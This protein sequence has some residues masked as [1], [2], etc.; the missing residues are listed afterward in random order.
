MTANNSVLRKG[1]WGAYYQDA[2][3]FTITTGRTREECG[4]SS[5]NL[6]L[7]TEMQRKLQIENLPALFHEFIHYIHELSTH[8][9]TISMLMEM[10]QRGVFSHWLEKDLS[11]SVSLGMKGKIEVFD[12]YVKAKACSDILE[13]TG[14]EVILGKLM[15]ML[16][17][18]KEK[19]V[20]DIPHELGYQQFEVQ[21]P[22]ITF[23]DRKNG[24]VYETKLRF[25]K[26]YIYEGIAYELDREIDRQV[27]GLGKIRDIN[28]NS[29][30]T[31][32]RNVAI[33]LY[34]KIEKR[35]FLSLAVI[36]LQQADCGIA[37]INLVTGLKEYCKTQG[38][39]ADFVASISR[40]VKTQLIENQE[41]LIDTV[42]ECIKPYLGRRELLEG[43]THIGKIFKQL[44]QERIGN[45][46][47]EVDAVMDG[48]FLAL[49]DKTDV[50]DYMYIFKDEKPYMR[51]FL[52]SAG[53]SKR[54]NQSMKV[55]IAYQHYFLSHQFLATAEVEKKTHPCPFFHC[56]NLSHRRQHPELCGS[57]PW[58]IYELSHASDSRYCEY[59][60]AVG[61]TKGLTHLI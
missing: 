35:I 27:N 56:C 34:S 49:L 8:V 39:Q 1:S 22:V 4:L 59:G 57:K 16:F 54:L 19:Q 14:K 38:S 5:R 47:F 41:N 42:E 32:L 6:Q 51:D 23:E 15:K 52:G 55:L 10:R 48:H 13:G 7:S 61:Q 36:A 18:S 9:G 30:Y 28:R 33:H 31:V 29:E 60:R 17:F 45:P 50:C 58:R 11:S 46:C 53:I 25:G 26:F 37:F 3:Y 40:S 43:Y 2:Y 21:V 20:M 12:D 44:V 24:I